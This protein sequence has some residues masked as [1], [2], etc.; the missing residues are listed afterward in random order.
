[1]SGGKKEICWKEKVECVEGKR[2]VGG[3]HLTAGRGMLAERIRS[4][5]Y[6]GGRMNVLKK[7]KEEDEGEKN[8]DMYRRRNMVRNVMCEEE[9]KEN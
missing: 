6:V 3:G 9:W 5:E 2:R 7:E 1:M 4:V 8:N